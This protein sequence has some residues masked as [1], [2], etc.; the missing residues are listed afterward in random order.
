MNFGHKRSRNKF[1]P[2]AIRSYDFSSRGGLPCPPA[3]FFC[4]CECA[5]RRMWQPTLYIFPQSPPP[6]THDLSFSSRRLQTA[7]FFLVSFV[8]EPTRSILDTRGVGINSDLQQY[9]RTIF[10]VEA[11]SHARPHLFFVIANA[12]FGA[13]GNPEGLT[14]SNLLGFFIYKSRLPH[15][16]R[17]DRRRCDEFEFEGVR[18]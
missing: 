5:V 16:A 15:I 13:C 3:S 11:G 9:D 7:F 6:T 17:N 1:R 12:P 8:L 4:R 2:T 14:E 10:T 18:F